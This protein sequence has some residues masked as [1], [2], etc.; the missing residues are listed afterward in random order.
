MKI[1]TPPRAVATTWRD[2]SRCSG[3]RFGCVTFGRRYI[4]QF[5]G[6]TNPSRGGLNGNRPVAYDSFSLFTFPQQL[7]K[8]IL[9]Q[10]GDS[11]AAVAARVSYR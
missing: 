3:S 9:L 8:L 5:A 1:S 10:R 4:R 7:N 6:R 11:V 2:H